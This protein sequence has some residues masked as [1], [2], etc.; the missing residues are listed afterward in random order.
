MLLKKRTFFPALSTHWNMVRFST[1]HFDNYV[2]G[3]AQ[4]AGD[5][6]FA[7]HLTNGMGEC[8]L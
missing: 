6:D 3:N 5:F 2:L 4:L 7:H 1:H 8:P